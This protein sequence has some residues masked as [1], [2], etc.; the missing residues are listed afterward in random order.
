MEA[1]TKVTPNLKAV[2]ETEILDIRDSLDTGISTETQMSPY[3]RVEG[4]S[5]FVSQATSFGARPR[6]IETFIFS[7]I[8]YR[9]QFVTK[10]NAILNQLNARKIGLF[11]MQRRNHVIKK[12]LRSIIQNG[13]IEI[14]TVTKAK[15]AA[16]KKNMLQVCQ[17]QKN[18]VERKTFKNQNGSKWLRRLA[19]K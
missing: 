9:M 1:I 14:K 10:S 5:K 3:K 19:K 13:G 2:K 15:T 18:G 17:D 11:W 6:N 16:K 7:K 4:I 12:I 8:I